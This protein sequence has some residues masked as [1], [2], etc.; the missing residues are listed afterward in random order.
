MQMLSEQVGGYIKKSSWIRKM[1]ETGIELKAQHGEDAVCDFSLGNPDLAPPKAVAT[2]IGNV[3]EAADKPF[4]FGYMPNPG[5]PFAREALAGYLSKEQGVD[6]DAGDVIITC[7]AAGALNV[8]MRAV[9]NPGDEVLSPAPYFVEYGFYTQNHGGVFKSVP[10]KPLTFEL[11][12]EALEA[13]I[14]A[15]TR[16]VL[17][18]SPN[19]PSG[20]V[21]AKEE[22]EG[23]AAILKAKSEEYGRPIYLVADEPYRF[24]VFDGIEVPSILPLY[25]YAIAVS[26]FSKNLSLAGER[27]GYA[28]VAPQMPGKEQLL[29]GLILANRILGFVNAPAIGQKV[30]AEAIGSQVNVTVYAERRKAMTKVLDDAGYNFTMPKG[31]FYFFPEAPGGDDVAFCAALQEELILAV[32]GS[33]FGCP[34]YFRLAFCVGE[35][36]IRRSA[37]GFKKAYRKL[38]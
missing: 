16:I 22:L 24:L 30:M 32:P 31:A 17:I 28:T 37:E 7:G 34:G 29:G 3:A 19:N 35:E 25:D 10:A 13:G 38:A 27:V 9:L 14:N 15:K 20:A 5:Y 21:Y 6:I 4:A 18:N 8:I 1:F 33:G 12:L 23:L 36:V 11:D 2:A 26:S